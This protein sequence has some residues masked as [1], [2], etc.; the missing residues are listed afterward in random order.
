MTLTK[1]FILMLLSLLMSSSSWFTR[2]PDLRTP[3]QV[4]T[5][6]DSACCLVGAPCCSRLAILDPP[7]PKI[8]ARVIRSG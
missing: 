8:G 6:S 5:A 3:G 1:W 4:T 2:E 7:S